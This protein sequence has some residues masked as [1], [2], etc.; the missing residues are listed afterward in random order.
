[1]SEQ[2]PGGVAPA[3]SLTDF[4]PSRLGL[5]SR[6]GLAF[7]YAYIRKLPRPYDRSSTMLG[8]VVHHG[9]E[10]WY[11]LPG[12]GFKTE[13]LAPIILGK[14]ETFLP[15][16]IWQRVQKLRDLDVEQ[17]AVAAAIKFQKP[18]LKAPRQTKSFLE[19]NAARAFQDARQDML[20]VCD[21][22]PEVKWSK[23][24][25]PWAAYVLSAKFAETMQARWRPKPKPVAVE[26]PF[27]VEISGFRVRGKID[28]VRVD[29]I[30][31]TGEALAT[32]VDMKT[33][34]QKLTPMEAFIQAF[35]YVKACVESEDLPDTDRFAIYGVRKDEYQQGRV[36]LVR[37]GRL[38][39]RILNGR[40]RQIAM[41]QFEPSYGFWCKSCDFNAICS[42][43]ISLWDGEFGTVQ[44]LMS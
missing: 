22:L 21:T 37:H 26:V 29:P 40:A 25:D 38:A 9:V 23:T 16:P 13:D 35:I 33:G 5:A 18:T 30:P 2:H 20:E 11:R 17:A 1:V 34:P 7:E 6:C 43:E 19:S 10:D 15:E 39:S 3:Q 31:Q 32:V 12:D 14:W 41:G 44:E 8:D 36:D 42:Q 27:V 24:E 4:S 28:Q